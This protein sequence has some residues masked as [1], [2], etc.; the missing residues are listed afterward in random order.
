MK[1]LIIRASGSRIR[2]AAKCL[3]EPIHRLCDLIGINELKGTNPLHA[4]VN[5]LLDD[6][7]IALPAFES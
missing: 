2:Q 5:M 1:R 6:L 4:L 3:G 7:W